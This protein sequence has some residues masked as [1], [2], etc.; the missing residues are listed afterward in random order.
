MTPVTPS[1][2][3][4]IL[5]WPLATLLVAVLG[6]AAACG[7]HNGII[8]L[9][10]V[11]DRDSPVLVRVEQPASGWPTAFVVKGTY[12]YGSGNI[13]VVEG[14]TVHFFDESCNEITQIFARSVALGS[15]SITFASDGT[16]HVAPGYNIMGD[17]T[18]RLRS[19]HLRHRTPA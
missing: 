13:D 11:N 10:V 5:R 16:W 18:G 15:P 6:V 9:S 17:P 14:S 7:G 2:G 3:T 19:R 1:V 12:G 4:G 8:E